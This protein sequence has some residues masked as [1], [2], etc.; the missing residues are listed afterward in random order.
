MRVLHKTSNSIV[1][2]QL[3]EA[4]GIINVPPADENNTNDVVQVAGPTNTASL[5]KHMF[6]H[7]TPSV[8]HILITAVGINFF[9][10]SSGIDALFL[11]GP[12]VFQKAG[13]T[14]PIKVYSAPSQSKPLSC[15]E[16]YPLRLRIVGTSTA[17]AVN[18]ATSGVVL[19]SSIT[20]TFLLY[21]GFATMAW[22]LFY[23]MLP[24][25]KGKT[26][27]EMQELFGNFVIW[28]S[29]S[30]SS[31]QEKLQRQADNQT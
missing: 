16:I 9:R 25:T 23:V 11:Y 2:P 14:P 3:Q 27:E 6:H 20:L 31:K 1:E 19:S 15:S 29:S 13:I 17:V 22:V 28:R 12:T 18:R 21:A 30:S 10:L 5:L 4:V 24:E 7:P 26:L 8:L